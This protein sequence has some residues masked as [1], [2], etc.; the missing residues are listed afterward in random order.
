MSLPCGNS[1]LKTL[2]PCQWQTLDLLTDRLD[3]FR[4]ERRLPDDKG[5]EDD[6]N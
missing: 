5:A 2:V 6:A 4:L 3:V 1:Y